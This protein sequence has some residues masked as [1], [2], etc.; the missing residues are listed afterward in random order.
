MEDKKK[1]FV[2]LLILFDNNS[3]EN[4]NKKAFRPIKNDTISNSLY[5]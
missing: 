5:L 1:L 4:Y 3:F 2:A